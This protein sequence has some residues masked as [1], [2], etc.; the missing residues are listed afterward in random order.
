[1]IDA[2]TGKRRARVSHKVKKAA[3]VLVNERG[4]AVVGGT[5]EIAAFDVQAGKMVWRGRYDPPS[6]GILRT[7]LAV[8]ARAA[9]IYFRYGGVAVTALRGTQLARAASHLRWSGLARAAAPDLTALATNSAREYVSSRFSPFGIAARA[10][11]VSNTRA[12]VLPQPSIDIEERLLDRIDPSN[13]LARLSRFLWRRRQLAALRAQWMY[14]Y[15]DLKSRVGRGL[16]SVNVN[17]G[18]VDRAIP[19]NEP[20]DRFI[21]DEAGALLYTSDGDRLLAFGVSRL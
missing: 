9:S 20:D 11:Q 8:A 15:T 17:T 16:A 7:M 10:S 6:R 18:A 14:F 1:L 12:L 4:H 13:Q 19:L 2:A 21:V 5:G 3:F